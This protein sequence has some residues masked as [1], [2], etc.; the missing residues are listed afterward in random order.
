MKQCFCGCGRT[1]RRFPLGLRSM[2]RRG[3]QVVDRLAFVEAHGGRDH[4]EFAEWLEA[5]NVIAAELATAVHGEA[6]PRAIEEGEVRD[7]QATGR[8]I[9]RT[10]GN[11]RYAVICGRVRERGLG[12]Q[13]VARGVQRGGL[14]LDDEE[15]DALITGLAEERDAEVA[16]ISAG[17]EPDDVDRIIAA[18]DTDD[19]PPTS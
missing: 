16:R 19:S 2:N 3:K 15:L 6:D 12:G 14:D 4:S 13:E 9:E 5:G 7:W 17:L 11:P 10:V 1:I 18:L 8:E